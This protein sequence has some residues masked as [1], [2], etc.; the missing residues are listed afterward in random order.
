MY[1]G[2]KTAVCSGREHGLSVLK[3]GSSQV[4]RERQGPEAQQHASMAP[5]LHESCSSITVLHCWASKSQAGRQI[6]PASQPASQP[7][8][9]EWTPAHHAMQPWHWHF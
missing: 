8:L 1:V 2:N 7:H 3:E 5:E 4:R 6:Q 9:P